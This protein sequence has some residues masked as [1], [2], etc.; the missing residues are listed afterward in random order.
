MTTSTVP[1]P[2]LVLHIS[3]ARVKRLGVRRPGVRRPGVR[4]TGVRRTG[5]RRT[6]YKAKQLHHWMN[7]NQMFSV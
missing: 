7:L 6:G 1:S 2:T 3:K 5:V 4:R